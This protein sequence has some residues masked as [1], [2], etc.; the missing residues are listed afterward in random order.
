MR[1]ASI[2]MNAIPKQTEENNAKAEKL[3][4][5]AS[6][7]GAKIIVLPEHYST[8]YFYKG[9]F[10][11]SEP[12]GG[13][14]TELFKKVAR[15]RDVYVVVPF[16]EKSIE[17]CFCSAMLVGPDGVVGKYR[18]QNLVGTER[19][20]YSS[21][22]DIGIF[23]TEFGRIGILLGHD[24]SSPG[25]VA[26]YSGVDCMMVSSALPRMDLMPWLEG[27]KIDSARVL[28]LSI[29][30]Q[31]A[32]PVVFA[33]LYG[34]LTMVIPALA[35]YRD[36]SEV[37]VFDTIFS[38]RSFISDYVGNVLVE[39]E[40]EGDSVLVADV[41]LDLGRSLRDTMSSEETVAIL[42]KNIFKG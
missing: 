13:P 23:A 7:K 33:N 36:F 28:P 5:E 24:I 4:I 38:G 30:M 15:D 22:P 10:D 41:D 16:L 3:V 12:L 21:S 9:R 31:L 35:E 17:G 37:S 39:A 20:L 32:C 27:Q 25:L 42:R 29:S 1:V 40:E 6:R 11:F 19:A 34:P 18:K 2:Q 26:R 8:G 14:T